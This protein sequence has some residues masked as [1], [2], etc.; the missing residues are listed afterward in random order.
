M[1]SSRPPR[2]NDE[3]TNRG[4]VPVGIRPSKLTRACWFY[5]RSLKLNGGRPGSAGGTE[6]SSPGVATHDVW[7]AR[8]VRVDI[9]PVRVDIHRQ[10]DALSSSVWAAS[11]HRP[12]NGAIRGSQRVAKRRDH[13]DARRRRAGRRAACRTRD[14][15][16]RARDGAPS[17]RRFELTTRNAL[18]IAA[19]YSED[20]DENKRNPRAAAR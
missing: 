16:S 5:N 18:S 1:R 20:S 11:A 3:G 7:M 9:H 15:A 14:V 6:K 4:T 19:R 13:G 2:E 8:T 17:E 12:I 10:A